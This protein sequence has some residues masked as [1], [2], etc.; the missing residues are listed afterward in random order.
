MRE[1]I[2]RNAKGL[3]ITRT[4]E[5]DGPDANKNQLVVDTGEIVNGVVKKV[6]NRTYYLSG[7][8]DV[9]RVRSFDAADKVVDE[10]LIKHF[11]D[12]KQPTLTKTITAVQADISK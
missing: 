11:D 5:F 7:A 1:T 2:Q 12:G 9:I 8:V 3:E 10:Y 6:M 4:I